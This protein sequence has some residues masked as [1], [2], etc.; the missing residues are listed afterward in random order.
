[1]QLALM[2]AIFLVYVIMAS[3][4]ESISHPFVILE[5]PLALIGVVGALFVTGTAVSVVVLIGTIALSGVVVNNASSWWTQSISAG[6][7]ASRNARPS[8]VPQAPTAPHPHHHLDDHL[9]AD[10]AGAWLR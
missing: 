8:S 4:F 3:T 7:R 6:P 10:A 2:L 1:M 9:G 5:V